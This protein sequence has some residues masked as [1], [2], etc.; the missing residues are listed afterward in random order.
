MDE[1]NGCVVGLINIHRVF[2]SHN[3]LVKWLV[4][5][6]PQQGPKKAKRVSGHE[7]C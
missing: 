7:R 5:T 4:V 1:R 6:E 2:V 3:V